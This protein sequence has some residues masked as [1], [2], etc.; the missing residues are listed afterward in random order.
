M[1]MKNLSCFDF[2]STNQIPSAEDGY[3]T[4]DDLSIKINKISQDEVNLKTHG[5]YL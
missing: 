2:Q 3:A 1:K 5:K 4:Y